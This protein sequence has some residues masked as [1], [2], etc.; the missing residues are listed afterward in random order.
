MVAEPALS[1]GDRR[2]ESIETP[3]VIVS[4]A[5][6]GGGLGAPFPVEW[7]ARRDVHR[8]STPSPGDFEVVDG[9]DTAA[10]GAAHDTA[11]IGAVQDTAAIGAA[12]GIAATGAAHGAAA[13][14]A[15]GDVE[16]AFS[17]SN[18]SNGYG[19]S[20]AS[21]WGDRWTERGQGSWASS[22]GRSD[23]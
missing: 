1:R 12:H 11:A 22:R 18:W 23:W 2:L 17:A 21:Q 8:E 13:I 14:G 4:M 3:V 20:G 15:E 10:I 19:D 5:S 16:G 7:S 9:D 6:W